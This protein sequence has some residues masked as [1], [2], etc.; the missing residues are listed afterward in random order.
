M[1]RVYVSSTYEDLKDYRAAAARAIRRLH[2][3]PV[4]M[5]DD[6]A[7]DER[8]LQRC[9]D[10]VRSCQAYVGLFAWR[11][12]FKP[13]GQRCGI[14][15]LEY[16]AAREANLP[17]F[18]FLVAPDHP[19]PDAMKDTDPSEILDVRKK[20]QGNHVVSSFTTPDNLEA[21]VSPAVSRWCTTAEKRFKIPGLLRYLADR[22]LQEQHLKRAI[23]EHAEQRRR[24][25]IFVIVHGDEREAHDRFLERLEKISLPRLWKLDPDAERVFSYRV[26]WSAPSLPLE[27][28]LEH[29]RSGLG[30]ELGEPTEDSI[31]ALAARVASH[32]APVMVWSSVLSADWMPHEPDLIRRWLALWEEWPDLP[33]NQRLIVVLNVLYQSAQEVGF[34]ERRRL[35]KRGLEIRELIAEIEHTRRPGVHTVVLPELESVLETDVINWIEEHAVAFVRKTCG[36]TREA[37]DVKEVLVPRVRELFRAAA[38]RSEVGA[39][40]MEDLAKAMKDMLQSALQPGVG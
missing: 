17:C 20:L 33:P 35:K 1:I 31:E 37:H 25:P 18:I 16:Q 28:R 12:G 19:W 27:D 34:F 39:V 29:L 11:V 24:R 2:C 3:Y 15:Y 14:T 13:P 7:A 8:P 38:A 40:P 4:A 6:V 32:R 22:S 21:L 30:K 10:D 9:L 5:E 36:T 26:S 23:R